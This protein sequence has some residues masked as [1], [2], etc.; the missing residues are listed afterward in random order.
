[1]EKKGSG[2]LGGGWDEKGRRGPLIVELRGS[3]GR[4]V[5]LNYMKGCSRYEGNDIA[6]KSVSLKA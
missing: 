5:K 6:L 1:M 3:E 2:W 4:Q